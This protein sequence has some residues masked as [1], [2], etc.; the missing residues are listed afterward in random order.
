[1][2]IKAYLSVLLKRWWMIVLG[3]SIAIAAAAIWTSRQVPKFESEATFVIRP[4]TSLVV[5]KEFVQALDI[6]SRRV[7]INTTFAE[8]SGSRSIRQVAVEKLG[9]TPEQT[10]GLSVS[11]VVIG[12][13][14]ILTITA[15][16][17]DPQVARDFANEVGEATMEYANGLYD[18]FELQPL[19]TATLPSKPISPNVTLNL[20]I[21]AALGLL[22][23]LGAAFLIEYIQSPYSEPDSFNIIDR[24]TG[25][26][27]KSYFMLRTWQEINRARR[28]NYPLTLVLIKID[29][30]GETLNSRQRREAM[31]V[32]KV[33]AEKTI[34]E[35]D[36]LACLN[37]DTFA[38]LFPYMQNA[39][40]AKLAETL[41]ENIKSVAREVLP[42]RS[43]YTLQT[44]STTSTFKSEL[45]AGDSL[46]DQAIHSLETVIANSSEPVGI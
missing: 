31:R 14:N 45:M 25:A 9:L 17:A 32:F 20:L 2:E 38:I 15:T 43:L 24:E 18:V 36:L 35:D 44:Y 5:D 39:K 4:R 6:V 34:R 10:R 23:G 16:G 22:I 1:M 29:L 40:A 30:N 37:G 28:N 26:Y 27:N 8:V 12:G 3:V 42:S 19:D 7:E 13:T 33:L 46:I 11:G 41:K 21:S